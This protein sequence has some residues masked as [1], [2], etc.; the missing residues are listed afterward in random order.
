MQGDA[1]PSQ[2]CCKL[3]LER[4]R[5]Q[6]MQQRGNTDGHDM[7]VPTAIESGRAGGRPQEELREDI[8]WERPS[9]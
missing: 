1:R 4:V 9:T 5:A 2:A 3:L 7:G 6:V 8:E